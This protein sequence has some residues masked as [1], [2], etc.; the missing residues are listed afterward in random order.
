MSLGQP[1]LAINCLKKALDINPKSVKY[2]SE[3]A[4]VFINTEELDNA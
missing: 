1:Q 2:L 4:Y 3:L